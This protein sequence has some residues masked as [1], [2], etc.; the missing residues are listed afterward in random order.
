MDRL[1][2]KYFLVLWASQGG[3]AFGVEAQKAPDAKTWSE[4]FDR[5]QLHRQNIPHRV[6][7]LES[8]KRSSSGAVKAVP[9]DFNSDMCGQVAF[10]SCVN[11]ADFS[12][13]LK[14]NKVPQLIKDAELAKFAGAGGLIYSDG[15]GV[16]FANAYGKDLI[17]IKDAPKLNK[18]LDARRLFDRLLASLGYDG[19]VL[20]IKGD[21]LLVG[22]FDA[23]LKKR[24]LQGLLIKH[25]ADSFSINSKKSKEG[26]ALLSLVGY[27]GGFAVFKSI[28]GGDT[29]KLGQKVLI[30]GHR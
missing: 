13:G 11:G 7:I 6:L 22:T 14:I 29:V 20:D 25:S 3:L 10:I 23:R 15:D 9:L 2:R 27:Y 21:Y 5:S 17:T 8:L 12:Y 26:A 28:I 30:E 24:D 1:I 19:I 16:V 18:K 4:T